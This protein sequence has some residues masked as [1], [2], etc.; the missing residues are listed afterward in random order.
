M[1]V[2]ASPR[3]LVQRLLTEDQV[4]S[5]PY[6]ALQ[7]GLVLAVLG[8]VAFLLS[9][10]TRSTLTARGFAWRDIQFYAVMLVF[11]GGTLFAL[12]ASYFKIDLRGLTF[13]RLAAI[14][15]NEVY[16]PPDEGAH[17]LKHIASALGSLD[18]QWT[19]YNRVGPADGR[20][21]WP[22]VLVGPAGVFGLELNREDPK[23]RHYTDPAPA[24]E[25]ACSR[26]QGELSASV[27]PVLLFPRSAADYKETRKRVRAFTV[28]EALAWLASRPQSLDGLG[29]Q[30]VERWFQAH[31]LR[32][33]S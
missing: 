4:S 24:L 10:L 12:S 32:Q 15:R 31:L 1:R 33:P 30:N 25:Q 21:V 7:L 27:I 13:D 3:A 5:L 29:R 14:V 28:E 8:A 16:V 20:T 19:L 11:V 6:R 18:D 26:L 17:L 22:F 23:K 9:F 2:V